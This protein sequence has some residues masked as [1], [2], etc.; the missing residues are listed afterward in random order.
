[1]S[2]EP[3]I[4]D[5]TSLFDLTVEEIAVLDQALFD[6]QMETE[7]YIGSS[8]TLD[9]HDPC[10]S[11]AKIRQDMEDQNRLAL[12]GRLSTIRAVRGRI[13]THVQ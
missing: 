13:P 12:E 3:D 8:S 11:K 7:R 4:P 6:Y 9:T 10:C 2:T 1:M 5:L